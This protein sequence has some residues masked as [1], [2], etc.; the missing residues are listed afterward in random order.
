MG[1]WPME[2]KKNA[3]NDNKNYLWSSLY[4]QIHFSFY[5]QTKWSVP[6]KITLKWYYDENRTFPF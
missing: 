1:S 3:S 5:S 4:I 2:R 6:L